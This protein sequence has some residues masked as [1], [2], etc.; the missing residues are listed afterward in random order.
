MTKPNSAQS[1][2]EFVRERLPADGL[3]AGHSWRVA[4]D[5]FPL[6]PALHRELETLGRVLLQFYHAANLLYRLSAEDRQPAWIAQWLDQGKPAEQIA[7]QRSPAFKNQ[8]PRVIRPDLILTQ[9]GFSIA[10]L[11]SVPGGIGL[12][13]WLNEVYADLLDAQGAAAPLVPLPTEPAAEALSSSRLGSAIVGGRNGMIDGFCRIFGDAP[14]VH[15][16][17]SEESATYRPEMQWLATRCG[18]SR[19]RL[20]GPSFAE[21]APGDAVYRFFELFDLPD[22]PGA[23]RLFELAAQSQI[24]LTPPPKAFLEEK[25]LLGL[26]WN[27]HLHGFWRRELGEGFLQRLQRHVPYTWIVDPSPLPPHAA[28]P[29]LGLTDWHQLK[30]L[31]QRQRELVLKASGFSPHA[32]GAR[33]VAVGH[34]LSAEQWAEAVDRALRSFAETPYVLQRYHVPKP[35]RFAYYDESQQ[36]AQTLLGRVRL[37]PYYFVTGDFSQARAHL[38]GVLATV[39]PADKKVIHGMSQAVLAPCCG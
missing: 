35:V 8:L 31:S 10:E 33:S 26:L 11:D 21:P 27:R 5:P 38:A 2:F 24:S 29:E 6:D 25:M 16:V 20:Q 1:R 9:E 39:C 15:I 13:A 23:T 37:C 18:R 17:V 36:A 32:W 7:R 12:T 22:V 19:F 34:D 14:R 4:L 30:R 28:I 3:F